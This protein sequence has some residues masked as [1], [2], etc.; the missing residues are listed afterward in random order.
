MRLIIAGSR[1]L[2]PSLEDLK[3]YLEHWSLKPSE[4]VSGKASGV[5]SAGETYA[6]KHQIT[7]K[8]FPAK[9]EENATKT[10]KFGKP[11]NPL[12][13][14]ERN[15]KMA[16]Y[17]DSLLLIWDGKSSGSAN[18]KKCAEEKGLNIYE[19]TITS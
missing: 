8:V 10:N 7:L 9:W 16:D 19:V 12:A 6:R 13:G 18:M 17:A 4:I 14:H 5:D 15:A 11:Y 1:S 3:S 2:N